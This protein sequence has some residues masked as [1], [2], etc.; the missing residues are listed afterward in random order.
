M[1]WGDRLGFVSVPHPVAPATPT[2]RTFCRHDRSPNSRPDSNLNWLPGVT[3]GGTMKSLQERLRE[4]E[5]KLRELTSPAHEGDT[6]PEVRAI[7]IDTCTSAIAQ[8][9]AEL[10]EEAI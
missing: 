6:T 5:K 4:Y 9:K 7:L 10:K 2:H 1:F 8:I 3:T